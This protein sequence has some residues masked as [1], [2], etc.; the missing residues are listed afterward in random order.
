MLTDVYITSLEFCSSRCGWLI[1]NV[2]FLI[3]CYFLNIFKAAPP[4][5][6]VTIMPH[7]DNRGTV[8]VFSKTKFTWLGRENRGFSQP[9]GNANKVSTLNHAYFFIWKTLYSR[10]KIFR[11]GSLSSS[12][13][14]GRA[15]PKSRS[16]LFSWENS[17]LG[18]ISKSIVSFFGPLNLTV[19]LE[20]GRHCHQDEGVFK[21]MKYTY[22]V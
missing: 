22:S 20:L 8:P 4:E 18:A 17:A 11:V 9:F 12:S 15:S 10:R 7:H 19:S 2:M 13:F 3:V 6:A 14:M 21:W 5:T 16:F 1:A